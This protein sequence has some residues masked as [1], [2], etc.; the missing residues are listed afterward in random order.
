ME[1][2]MD[3]KEIQDELKTTKDDNVKEELEKEVDELDEEENETKEDLDATLDA[4]EEMVKEYQG[5]SN[6]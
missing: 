6:S 2:E 4:D 3:K 1:E 5:R